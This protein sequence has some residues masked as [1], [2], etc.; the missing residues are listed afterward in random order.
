MHLHIP[1]PLRS[2]FL[3][4]AVLC[5]L[6]TTAQNARSLSNVD[7]AGVW[8]G[9]YDPVA[10][11]AEGKAVKGLPKYSYDHQG[12][13]YRFSTQ[14]YLD[15]F[16]RAPESFLPQYGGYCAYAMGATGE[17]VEVDPGTFKIKDGK[18]YLFYN[19]FFNNTLTKW[20]ADEKRLLSAADANWKTLS[21][22]H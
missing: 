20:N 12:V 19:A 8:L 21:S 16:K 22:K 18:L 4:I 3:F 13:V 2:T 10:Y 7:A 11:K 9:G 15:L 1:D 6:A 14:A 5:S 17:K